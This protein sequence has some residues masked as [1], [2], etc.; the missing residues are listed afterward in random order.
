MLVID[1]EISITM[2]FKPFLQCLVHT[3]VVT[4]PYLGCGKVVFWA[5]NVTLFFQYM[6]L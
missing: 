3:S 5:H 2:H 4:F 1:G 6:E